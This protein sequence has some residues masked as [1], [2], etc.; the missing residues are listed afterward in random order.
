MVQPLLN[1]WF[2]T[3]LLQ[4]AIIMVASRLDAGHSSSGSGMPSWSLSAGGAVDV[5]GGIVVGIVVTGSEVVVD[6]GML[7]DVVEAMVVAG[8]VE[9]VVGMIDEELLD[10]VGCTVVVVVGMLVVSTLVVGMIDDVLLLDE[11]LDIISGVL[12]MNRFKSLS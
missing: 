3:L 11:E 2:F 10:V 1:S 5:V 7:V 4:P 9:V 8:T 12:K 6:A